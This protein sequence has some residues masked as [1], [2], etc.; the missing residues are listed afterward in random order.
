MSGGRGPGGVLSG[1]LAGGILHSGGDRRVLGMSGGGLGL[2][3]GGS[4]GGQGLVDC[5]GRLVSGLEGLGPGKYGL[6]GADHSLRLSGVDGGVGS[7]TIVVGDDGCVGPVLGVLVSSE[8]GD[9][10]GR[11]VHGLCSGDHWRGMFLS[12]NS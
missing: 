6:G 12:D 1:G 5:S 3:G 9:S 10:P 4:G 2:V 8:A 11:R 7:G